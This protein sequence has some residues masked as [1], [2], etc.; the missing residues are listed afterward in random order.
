MNTLYLAIQNTYSEVQLGLYQNNTR[1]GYIALHK[2]EASSLLAE[3]IP[4]LLAQHNTN[5]AQLAFLAVNQG[6]GPFTTLRVV[7][8]TVNGLSFALGIP[9]VGVDGIQTLVQEYG[10]DNHITVGLL[11]AFNQDVYFAVKAPSKNILIGSQNI[12]T[13]IEQLKKDFGDQTPITFIGNGT[14]MHTELI[15][16]YFPHADSNLDAPHCTLDAIASQGFLQ[17]KKKDQITRQ[18]Q[19]LYIKN[20][21]YNNLTIPQQ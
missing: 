9:L 13:L 11:N 10:N 5:L 2:H 7:I 8:A 17:W 16:S 21:V 19:P 1:L 20:T 15:H 14:A 4:E 3:K 6:P 18:L 12:T